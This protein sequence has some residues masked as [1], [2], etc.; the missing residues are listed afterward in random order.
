MELADLPGTETL[1]LMAQQ[2]LPEFR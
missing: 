1:T 2:V